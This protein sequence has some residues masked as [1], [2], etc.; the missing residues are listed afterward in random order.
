MFPP[1][2]KVDFGQQQNLVPDKMR[3]MI[4][5]LIQAFRDWLLKAP[6]WVRLTGVHLPELWLFLHTQATAMRTHT[7]TK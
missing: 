6:P 2:Q 3:V 7:F 1:E 5:S 4:D